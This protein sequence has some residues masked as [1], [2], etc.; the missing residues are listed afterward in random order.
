MDFIFHNNDRVVVLEF[1]NTS[2]KRNNSGFDEN[3]SNGNFDDDIEEFDYDPFETHDSLKT[4]A[5]DLTKHSGKP[6]EVF[7]LP[8]ENFDLDDDFDEDFDDDDEDE[9]NESESREENENY[10]ELSPEILS[11]STSTVATTQRVV[12]ITEAITSTEAPFNYEIQTTETTMKT[13]PTTTETL[14]TEGPSSTWQDE[15]FLTQEEVPLST[16]STTKSSI[17]NW[18]W[19]TPELRPTVTSTLMPSTSTSTTAL[20]TTA[21]SSSTSSTTTTTTTTPAPTTTPTTT[22]SSITTEIPVSSTVKTSRAHKTR[23]HHKKH[24]QNHAKETKV[25]DEN[26]EFKVEDFDDLHPEIEMK[27][28]E[29]STTTGNNGKRKQKNP[30]GRQQNHA[31]NKSSSAQQVPDSD[32]S[33]TSYPIQKPKQARGKQKNSEIINLKKETST[34]S[35]TISSSYGE[36]SDFVDRKRMKMKRSAEYDNNNDDDK[37]KDNN[38]PEN[39][40]PSVDE[41]EF[42]LRD[43]N[44]NRITPS[45]L[46]HHVSSNNY[47]NSVEF[48]RINKFLISIVGKNEKFDPKAIFSSSPTLEYINL[49]IALLVWSTRYPS[50]FWESSKA[51]TLIFSFQLLAN[52]LD[53]LVLYAG[54]GILFK[55]QTVGEFMTVNNHSSP[56]LLNGIVTLALTLLAFLLTILSSMILYLYG[57]SRLAAKIRDCKTITLK[58][59][60]VWSYFSHCASLCFILALAVVKAP[61]IHDLVV[62]YRISLDRKLLYASE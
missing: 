48:D 46:L 24:Q 29:K 42:I 15:D 25:I 2:P 62:S 14:T 34:K 40:S 1:S 12:V 17:K 50:V 55:V 60:D 44:G 36:Y 22:Q 13:I 16:Q 31:R 59:S 8:K 43:E 49:A 52:S 27:L 61:I 58:E 45:Q 56:L 39:A 3:A 20:P 47:S 7:K 6:K 41:D 35:A 53:I 11:T 4:P 9:S 18:Y 30:Q 23:K 26:P 28:G 33:E 51:F 37:I 21:T 19:S 5:S 32:S 54:T 38:L 10:K 57:H